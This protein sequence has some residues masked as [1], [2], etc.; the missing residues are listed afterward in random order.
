MGSRFLAERRCWP[1]FDSAA[2]Q[3]V[4]AGSIGVG[5]PSQSGCYADRKRRS[6]PA[7]RRG[8]SLGKQIQD[9]ERNRSNPDEFSERA[10]QP[11]ALL[12]AVTIPPPLAGV[13]FEVLFFRSMI[14]AKSSFRRQEVRV[15]FG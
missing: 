11:D 1:R 5:F 7:T 13:K 9:A 15:S 10:Y 14:G 2:R 8:S 6:H 12:A 3:E 4:R